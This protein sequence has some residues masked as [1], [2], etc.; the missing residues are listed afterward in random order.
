MAIMTFEEHINVADEQ[1]LLNR[2][3]LFLAS[4][5][6]TINHHIENQNWV[7][8]GGGVY[9]FAAGDEFFLDVSSNGYGN[10]TLHY[11]FRIW[12]A[13]TSR[14]YLYGGMGYGDTSFDTTVSN[15][16]V[17]RVYKPSAPSWEYYPFSAGG[18][19]QPPL[20]SFVSDEIMPRVWF[21]GF[22]QKYCCVVIQLDSQRVHY[23]H[24]G[25]MEMHDFNAD[26]GA[27]I[28]GFGN[29]DWKTQL[30]LTPF[31][32]NYWY[33]FDEYVDHDSRGGAAKNKNNWSMTTSAS[34]VHGE[35]LVSWAFNAQPRF[36]CHQNDFSELRPLARPYHYVID[37][38][39]G[40]WFYSGRPFYYRGSV[41]NHRI[42]ERFSI[43]VEDYISFPNFQVDLS[44]IGVIFRIG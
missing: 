20:Q 7:H 15:H 42:G 3:Q 5:G 25:T 13:L 4:Q 19:S 38:A 41:V 9:G 2:L 34:G 32:Y 37:P 26:Y 11:R 8:L 44:Q 14:R 33:G 10:Q 18:T 12:G 21:F 27:F 6:W 17:Q 29:V 43:S 35:Q 1:E 22:E 31:D 24:F 39:D 16:P 30:V 36:F 23:F 40:I 28:H